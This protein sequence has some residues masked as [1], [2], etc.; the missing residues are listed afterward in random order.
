MTQ[1]ILD[2]LIGGG[3]LACMA[4]VTGPVEVEIL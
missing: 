3:G 4:E 1:D 2:V